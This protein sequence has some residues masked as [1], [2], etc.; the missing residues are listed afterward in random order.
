MIESTNKAQ[1]QRCLPESRCANNV[2]LYC[3]EFRIEDFRICISQLCTR[4]FNSSDVGITNEAL[5]MQCT[6]LFL[7]LCSDVTF[8]QLLKDC[9]ALCDAD[10]L[11]ARESKEENFLC[12][13]V[14]QRHCRTGVDDIGCA[15]RCSNEEK[16]V[17]SCM[18]L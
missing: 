9:F 10:T 4:G 16:C 8:E 3:L 5:F 14:A 7:I 15:Q 2:T 1:L 17:S 13:K 6:E 12:D 11:V 18:V